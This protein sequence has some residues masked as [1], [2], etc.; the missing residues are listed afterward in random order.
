MKYTIS[1]MDIVI[2][3]GFIGQQDFTVFYNQSSCRFTHLRWRV[4]I[5]FAELVY[6]FERLFDHNDVL[7]FAL[8]ICVFR[9]IHTYLNMLSVPFRYDILHI[10]VPV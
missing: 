7:N 10:V 5:G 2:Y 9:F 8:G 3:I 6:Y 1:H 4:G